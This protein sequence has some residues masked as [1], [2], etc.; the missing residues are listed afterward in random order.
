M[1][2]LLQTHNEVLQQRKALL[3]ETATFSPVT[4]TEGGASVAAAASTMLSA[5]LTGSV[6]GWRNLSVGPTALTL[7]YDHPTGGYH[8]LSA[9]AAQEANSADVG[10]SGITLEFVTEKQALKPKRLT[11]GSEE[12][13][14]EAVVMGNEVA[15]L[16]DLH[17]T[18]L[19]R[20]D[21]AY[22]SKFQS[23]TT[24]GSLKTVSIIELAVLICR[25]L[26][27][28]VSIDPHQVHCDAGTHQGADGRHHVGWRFM[29]C[30]V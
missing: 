17:K 23:C 6:I 14:E 15:G 3:A 12:T 16:T 8:L 1:A 18:L 11:F 10:V 29:V 25:V 24:L 27:T 13:K 26:P 9:R 7:R 30:Q 5:F 28:L 22:A 20:L 4:P 21:S 2:S 19:Q